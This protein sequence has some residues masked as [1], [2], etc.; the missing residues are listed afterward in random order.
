MGVPYPPRPAPLV[1][2]MLGRTRHA[3]QRRPPAYPIPIWLGYSDSHGIPY[4]I[5]KV[6]VPLEGLE[7]PRPYG[8]Q[9]LSVLGYV[10]II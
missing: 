8:Q 6:L 1:P 9:I 4:R 5:L 10:V 2:L 3:A 7:P